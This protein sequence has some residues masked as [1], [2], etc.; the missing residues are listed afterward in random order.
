MN[1]TPA[2]PA[3]ARSRRP[4]ARQR[5]AIASA[6]AIA[7]AGLAASAIYLTRSEKA[8]PRPQVAV[9]AAPVLAAA[10]AITDPPP[11]TRDV[12]RAFEPEE[13]TDRVA[14]PPSAEAAPAAS[15]QAT[16]PKTKLLGDDDPRW[17]GAQASAALAEKL[18]APDLRAKLEA[19]KQ[20]SDQSLPALAMNET[21]GGPSDRQGDLD[22]SATSAIATKAASLLPESEATAGAVQDASTPPEGARDGRI[23]THV[24]MRAGPEN[25]AEVLAVLPT[26]AKVGVI[27]GCKHWC[28]VDFNGRRG[29]VYKSFISGS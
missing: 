11:D 14:L 21:A 10:T 9:A 18:E 20:P 29:Y 3:R 28:Q 19:L 4:V 16:A 17:G 8:E 5:L 25:E 12:A 27:G 26:G 6:S 1:P 7:L 15:E 23:N 22:G 2:D 13:R 24:N